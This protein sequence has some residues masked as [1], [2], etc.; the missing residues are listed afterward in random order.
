MA[1]MHSRR[2]GKA[3]SN[4]PITKTVPTWLRYK[5]KEIELLIVKLAK[6][7]KMQS[8]IGLILRDTYGIPDIKLITKKSIS[9]ILEEKKLGKELPEDLLN[10]IRKAVALNKHLEENK[11]DK[12]AKRGLQLTE[13][14]I[15]RLTTYYKK[16]GKL[17][18][19]WK[20]DPKK[21]GLL[22]E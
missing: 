1:R 22:T 5:P 20:Y 11:T 16:S 14:K 13:S 19:G 2:K 7:G 18:S 15:K 12:T 17:S 21:A 9:K 3:S 10:L 4:K 8:E 6:E